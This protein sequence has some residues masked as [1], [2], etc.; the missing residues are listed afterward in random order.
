MFSFIATVA[1]YIKYTLSINPLKSSLDEYGC[2]R[3]AFNVHFAAFLK[4][5]VEMHEN[6]I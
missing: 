3:P 5:D 6:I 1:K 2:I 4:H